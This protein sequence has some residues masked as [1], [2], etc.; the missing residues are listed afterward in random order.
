MPGCLYAPRLLPLDGREGLCLFFCAE[1]ENAR[2]KK[3]RCG[4]QLARDVDEF[5]TW[6]GD[7]VAKTYASRLSLFLGDRRHYLLASSLLALHSYAVQYS[8]RS[9]L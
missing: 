4:I 1:R 5:L 6:R 3:N 8:S 9:L 2:K 7:V